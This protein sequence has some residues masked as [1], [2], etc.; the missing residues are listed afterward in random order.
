[1]SNTGFAPGAGR[2][3]EGDVLNHMFEV[4]RFIAR[5]GMGEVFEGRN[6]MSGER[7]AIKVILPA[8]AADPKVAAMFRKEANALQSV[9]HEAVVRYV[10][11]A[12]EPQLG[13]EYI[14]TGFIE[15]ISLSDALGKI[16][17][18]VDE[19]IALTRRI[20]SGLK[21][22]HDVGVV[23]RDI[24]PD[25]ILLENDRL[26]RAR[27]IDFGIVKD[28][29][30]GAHTIIDNGFAGKMK[31]VA[32]EQLGD[33]SHSVG[34]WSDV[35]SLALVI[36]AL[37]QGEPAD[38]AGSPVDAITKRR[39]GIDTN[40][41]PEPLR[42]VLDRMLVP[43]PANR[44]RSMDEVIA[45]LDQLVLPQGGGKGAHQR[46]SAA[47]LVAGKVV[48][49]KPGMA[50]GALGAA[51][52]VPPRKVLIGG[53]VAVGVALLAA[54]GFIAFGGK[55]QSSQSTPTALPAG[56]T[57]ALGDVQQAILAS[58]PNVTCSWVDVAARADGGGFSLAG[59]GVSSQPAQVESQVF[60]AVR[61]TGAKLTS[62]D[63]AKVAPIDASYC[64]TL[65][66]L[67]GIRDTGAPRL[68]ASQPRYELAKIT[69]GEFTGKVG[70][71]IVTDISLGGVTD[72]FAMY[73]IEKSNEVSLLFGSRAQFVETA[74]SNFPLTQ[75]GK[76]KY[77]LTIIGTVQPGWSGVV[78]IT[79]RGGFS[80]KLLSDLSSVEG[81]A[82]FSKVA[83]ANGWKASIAWYKFI[84][85]VPN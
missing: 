41:V 50:A 43:D 60:D 19:L 53:G 25:N 4:T 33:F 38:L 23:H 45:A 75:I 28:T 67:R 49:Q 39:N 7:M 79:G 64:S 17:P 11:Q 82:R 47:G 66:A 40:A 83:Q 34:N 26:D 42:G 61:Q 16:Q 63:F 1:M 24:S 30:A 14:V 71:Q 65:D 73:T 37:A 5:G 18:G 55:S 77:R 57:V 31:F 3:K 15:G 69:E 52:H 80:D 32:P 51:V 46:G 6:I 68:M 21:K 72:D 36:L 44:L 62:S 54:A 12:R 35:Y 8:L 10:V 85:D 78:L 27:V 59:E 2:I 22:A 13:C 74:K 84:D 48:G 9:Q 56:K 81:R 70:A 76:D 58:L 20:A 29:N